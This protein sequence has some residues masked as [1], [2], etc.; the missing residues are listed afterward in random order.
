V[1]PALPGTL[2]QGVLVNQPQSAVEFGPNPLPAK[3]SVAGSPT[4]S[5]LYVQATPAGGPAG[6]LVSAPTVY[7]DSGDNF[8]SIPASVL[9][10]G[11]S[12]GTVPAGTV[13]SVYA[14]D[15]TTLLYTYT[16]G[17]SNGLTVTGSV[18][19]T[20]NPA[21]AQGPVYI[22]ESPSGTGTTTFDA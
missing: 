16:T 21:F 3:V 10:T 7:I 13:I 11:Q 18:M 1:I 2:D 17:A 5:N 20:G 15:G 9:A 6:P 14:S 22:G 12:S 19:N 4:T 8:G